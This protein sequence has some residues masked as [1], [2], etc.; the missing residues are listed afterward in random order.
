MLFTSEHQLI[1][2]VRVGN[3]ERLVRFSDPNANSTSSSFET[4]DKDVINAIRRHKFFQ[5][6][7]IKA[8]GKFPESSEPTSDAVTINEAEKTPKQKVWKTEQEQQIL[9]FANFSQLKNYLKKEYKEET[10]GIRTQSQVEA[11]AREKGITFKYET[12]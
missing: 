3:T 6:G 9:V 2:K 12:K 10:N 11:F 5:T 7:H 1:F 4:T 8:Y